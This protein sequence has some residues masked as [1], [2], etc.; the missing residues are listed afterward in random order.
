MKCRAVCGIRVWKT[1]FGEAEE[2]FRSD[3]HDFEASSEQ[4]AKANCTRWAD[5]QTEMQDIAGAALLEEHGELPGW[6]D[7]EWN[8]KDKAE[9][10]AW[11]KVKRE[12]YKK[13]SNSIYAECWRYSRLELVSLD[14]RKASAN[15]QAYIQLA[16]LEEKEKG[17]RE[18]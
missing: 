4:G 14:S 5:K 11:G 3:P 6:W 7:E 18:A 17:I 15:V 1:R 8:S 10:E 12:P 9:W 2:V 13:D 16:W